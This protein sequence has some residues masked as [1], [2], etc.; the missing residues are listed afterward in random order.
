MRVCDDL[1]GV[2]LPRTNNEAERGRQLS[3]K[4]VLVAVSEAVGHVTGAKLRDINAPHTNCV[5]S[6]RMHKAIRAL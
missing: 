4:H 1:D 5:A 2:G 6:G 3:A